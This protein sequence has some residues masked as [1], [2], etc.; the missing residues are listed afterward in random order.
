M[1]LGHHPWKKENLSKSNLL[2]PPYSVWSSWYQWNCR[3]LWKGM[4]GSCRTT[5]NYNDW[6][7]PLGKL[8]WCSC[9]VQCK[10][11][12]YWNPLSKTDSKLIFLSL[13]SATMYFIHEQ[14]GNYNFLWK[15]NHEQ[16]KLSLHSQLTGMQ[17]YEFNFWILF[18]ERR[19]TAFLKLL[20]DF[21]L[22]VAKKSDLLKNVKVEKSGLMFYWELFLYLMEF[23]SVSYKT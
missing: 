22:V 13:V 9:D 15:V 12:W 21:L 5:N 14:H 10:C 19:K 2:Q 17:L 1:V 11:S 18:R 7:R 3:N 23:C 16:H 20:S 8:Q 6:L 4:P